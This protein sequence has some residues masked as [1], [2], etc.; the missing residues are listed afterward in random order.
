MSESMPRGLLFA[1]ARVTLELRSPLTIGTGRGNDLVDAICVTDA[2]GLPT[3]PGSSLA[4]VL[5]AAVSATDEHEAR[6]LFGHQERLSGATSLV[7]VS[8][9]HAHNAGDRPVSA[10]PRTHAAGADP[11]LAFLQAGIVRDHVRI[12]ELGVVDKAGKFDQGLVPKG[13]RFTF[14]L[15]V[16]GT[17]AERARSDLERLLALLA[18]GGV[19]LGAKSRAGFGEIELVRALVRTFDL[20]RPADRTAWL[21]LPR[22]LSSDVAGL[23]NWGPAKSGAAPGI[24]LTLV[25]RDLWMFGTGRPVRDEHRLK[26]GK[27]EKAHDKVPVTERSI[28]WNGGRGTVLSDAEGEVLV[29]ASGVKGALRHRALFHARRRAGAWAGDAPNPAPD[30]A[31]DTLFGSAKEEDERRGRGCV[32]LSEVRL[33]PAH[34]PSTPLQ[35]VS[36]DRFTQAPMDGLLFSEAPVSGGSF[37]LRLSLTSKAP[38]GLGIEALLDAIEDLAR[39]RLALGAGSSR[40]HGYFE[41]AP[42]PP[43]TVL[44]TDLGLEP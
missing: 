21:A 16:H 23:E 29:P 10:A 11:V 34:A 3:V 26:V 20:T 4:G 14:E 18:A 43:R 31:I 2:N 35:H 42:A 13:A 24:A 12:D 22:A 30:E 5:R 17:S 19:R 1:L 28:R 41:A 39:G 36:I 7:E 27:D 8:W 25:A 40:G 33:A 9:A 44:R 32:L 6:R 37:T 38:A 15:I